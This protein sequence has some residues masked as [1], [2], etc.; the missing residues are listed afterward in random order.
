MNE[1]PHDAWQDAIH[2][3]NYDNDVGVKQA[4]FF[5]KQAMDTGNAHVVQSLNTTSHH[6]GRDASLFRYGDIGG[7][8]GHHQNMAVHL[9]PCR[10]DHDEPRVRIVLRSSIKAANCPGDRRF[11]ASGQKRASFFDQGASDRHDLFRGFPIT[12]YDFGESLPQ[13]PMVIK[14]RKA[15]IFIR[16]RSKALE[17]LLDGQ[18]PH[19]DLL[20]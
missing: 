9:P 1:S 16:E 17:P 7:A 15:K 2:S 10:V 8:G 6:L 19:M 3:R 13:R 20:K 18:S 12:E 5:P 4:I 14:R 11:R